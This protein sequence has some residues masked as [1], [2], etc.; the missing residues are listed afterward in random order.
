[1]LKSLE[2]QNF[3]GFSELR[4]EPLK[5]I[6][7]VTGENDTG[8]TALL[9][10]IYLLLVAH[11][12]MAGAL[13]SAFR[14]SQ[15][16]DQDDFKSFWEWLFPEGSTGLR[17]LIKAS[18]DSAPVSAQLAFTSPGEVKI[19]SGTSESIVMPSGCGGVRRAGDDRPGVV[20]QSTRSGHPVYDAE[21]YNRVSLTAG[22]E[23]K[24]L[25]LMRIIEPRLQKLRYSKITSQPLVYAH[26][27]F[28]HFLPATQMGQ[29]FSLAAHP[30][31]PDDGFRGQSPPDRRS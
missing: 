24:I 16:N 5:R 20:V 25:G 11:P 22:G 6:N 13:A 1:M 26:L 2:I 21:L 12:V 19:K 3:R 18:T 31:L 29:G 17:P 14:N 30:L 7:L 8:K 4:I 9:E 23:E 28:Q 15:G 10:A 27:G